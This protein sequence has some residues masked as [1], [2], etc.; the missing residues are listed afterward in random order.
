MN[1]NAV[2]TDHTLL[3]KQSSGGGDEGARRGDVQDRKGQHLALRQEPE[4]GGAAREAQRH[5][6]P[7]AESAL[8]RDHA[9][10]EH[11]RNDIDDVIRR[12]LEVRSPR[13]GLIRHE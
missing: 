11:I 9:V 2:S 6:Q 4:T 3:R 12:D 10:D 5:P 1:R 8:V 7:V 13:R